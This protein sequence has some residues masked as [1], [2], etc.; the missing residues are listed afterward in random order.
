MYIRIPGDIIEGQLPKSYAIKKVSVMKITGQEHDVVLEQ[1]SRAAG[2]LVESMDI[3]LVPAGGTKF[4]YALAGARDKN[5]IAGVHGGIVSQRGKVHA[6]GSC[7][8]GA[9]EYIGRI[10]LTAMKFDPRMRCAATIRFF[11]QVLPVIDNMLLECEAFD[12]SLEPPGISSMDW[13][14]AF[15]CKNGVPDICYDEGGRGKEPI[16]RLF[17]EKPMDITNNIIMISNRMIDIEL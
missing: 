11:P 15:C 9:D 1:L 12:P 2:L 10:V 13:G 16:I 8:Y 3:R 5:G 14:V 6:A 4:A 17:G 7:I